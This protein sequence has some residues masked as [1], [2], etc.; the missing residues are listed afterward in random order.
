[1]FWSLHFFYAIDLP[2]RPFFDEADPKLWLPLI[3]RRSESYIDYRGR[4][5]DRQLANV[6]V[7]GLPLDILAPA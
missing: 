4:A 6:N 3:R 7:A 5:I 1:M 2:K